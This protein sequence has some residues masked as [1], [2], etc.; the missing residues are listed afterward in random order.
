M[1]RLRKIGFVTAAILLMFF[2]SCRGGG[3]GASKLADSSARNRTAAL[4]ASGTEI[5]A[6]GDIPDF[7]IDRGSRVADPD[8]SE[9]M[10]FSN[11]P[12]L[13]DGR[14]W[15]DKSV[16]VNTAA[17]DFTVTLSALSQ[18]FSVTD[19]YVIPADTVF[20]FDVSGSM[21]DYHVGGD[22]GPLRIQVLVEALNE[23]IDI[24]M[25]ANP[26]NRVAV[27]AYGGRSQG[28]ARVENILPLGRPALMPSATDYFKYRVSATGVHY[29]DVNTTN[30]RT[31]YVRVEGSTPTQWG[32]FEGANILT[33]TN[34]TGSVVN[35]LTIPALNVET[36]LEEPG[37][38]VT[39]TPNIILMTD[40]EPTMAWR[41]FLFDAPPASIT[42][43]DPQ[44]ILL[45]S[46]GFYYGDG[47]YGEMGV[48]VLTVLTAAHR[49]RLIGEHYFIDNPAHAGAA[50]N[51]ERKVGFYT[52]GLNLED[53]PAFK[54]IEGTMFP[55][56]PANTSLP[57]NAS[58]VRPPLAEYMGAGSDPNDPNISM[59]DLLRDFVNPT[60]RDIT[61]YAQ[62]RIAWPNYS[63][64]HV[65][66][67]INLVNNVLAQPLTLREA[68]YADEFYRATDVEDLREAFRQITTNIQKQSTP[69]VIDTPSGDDQFD[70]YLVFSDVLGEYMKFGKIT[71]F[72]FDGVPYSIDGLGEAVET[73][74]AVFGQFKEVLYQNMNYGNMIGDPGYVSETR[75]EDLIKSNIEA[76][77]LQQYNSVKYYART[78]RDFLDSFFDSDGREAPADV[79]AAAVVEVFHMWGG[80]VGIE[81]VI[82]HE[83]M[84][85]ISIPVQVITALKDTAF[86][87]IFKNDFEENSLERTLKAGDQ[88]IRWYIPAG[89]I[90]LRIVS[91]EGNLD[92][93]NC[94]VLPI[95]VRYTVGLDEH[96]VRTEGVSD[97][98]MD[99]NKAPGTK[100][101]FYFYTNRNPENVTYAFY[102]PHKDN[103]FY[104]PGRPGYGDIE[105]VKSYN[106]TGT[107]KHVT[108]NRHKDDEDEGRMNLHWLGNNGRLTITFAEKL[109]S[110]KIIKTFE[111]LP[112]DGQIFNLV[113]N[114]RFQITGKDAGG[115][116]WQTAR[117]IYGP[118]EVFF[119]PGE[120]VLNA[121]LNRYEYTLVDLPPGYYQVREAGGDAGPEFIFNGPQP[122][123]IFLITDSEEP[124]SVHF[125]NTYT[126][127]TH[128]DPPILTVRKAFQG[129]DGSQ[130]PPAFQI[131][132]TGPAG[133]NVTLDLAAAENGQTFTNLPS[134]GQYRI[135]EINTDVPGFNLS[136]VLVNGRPMEFPYFFD[137]SEA[138]N[139]ISITINNV[140]TPIPP[141]P[142]GGLT[143][144]K[145]FEGLPPEDIFNLVSPITFLVV[146]T[147][148]AYNEIYRK[149]VAFTP[150]NF[151]L[152]VALN[153][154]ECTLTNLPLG[155]YRIYENGGWANGYIFNR[156]G[157]PQVISVTSPGAIVSVFFV[158]RYTPVDPP[159]KLPALTVRK[160]FQGLVNVEKP[161]T[162]QIHITGPGGFDKIL[163]IGA[164]EAG[165][166]FQDLELGEYRIE[167]INTGAPGFDLSQVL[168]DG[169]PVTEWPYIVEIYDRNADISLTI[170]N[171]YTPEPPP[172]IGNL[173]II[174]AFVGLPPDDFFDLVSP[175]TFLVVGTDAAY[176]EIYRKTVAFTPDNFTWNVAL[177]RYECTLTNLP[178]GNYR[179]YENGGWADG[180]IF[181]RPGPPQLISLTSPGSVVSVL[182]INSYEPA[183]PPELPAL[184]VRKAFHGLANAQKP[185]DFYIHITGPD[186]F[187]EKLFIDDAEAGKTF[188]NLALGEYAIVEINSD[189]PGFDLS[190]IT[191][192]GE[193]VEEWPYKI[194]I[195]D[196]SVHIS[197]TINNVYT[198]ELP[199]LTVLKAFHGLA[200]AQKPVGFYIHI[201]G[202]DG[203]DEKMLIDDAE[204]GKTF[205]NLAL[206]EYAIVEIN[207]DVPGFDLSEIT[208]NGEL[209]EEWPYKIVIS[210]TSVHISI[211]INNV[212]TPDPPDPPALTVRKAFHGLAN[213]QKPVGFYIHITGPGGF[214]EKV[215]INDA[216]AG[217]TFQNLAPGEYSIVEINSDVPGFDLS[218]ITINGE[219]VKKWPYKII[220][221]DAS[222]HISIT[223]NNVYTPE[224]PDPS[225][226][227]DPPTTPPIWPPIWPP[228]IYPWPPGTPPPTDPPSPPIEPPS[229]P[230]NPPSPPTDPP[231]IYPFSPDPPPPW[232]P[233]PS[234]PPPVN[235]S[236]PEPPSP[237]SPPPPAPPR[238][239]QTGD[240]R[241]TA[242]YFIML[243][244]GICF[245]GA[246]IGFGS[247]KKK[248]GNDAR[249]E[250]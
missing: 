213:A 152:N 147:D 214:D 164:S 86:D 46:P 123:P 207:S 240:Y 21:K 8:T 225:D 159:E 55:F 47:S 72:E 248:S 232:S 84:D 178:L 92:A 64:N 53:D 179:I 229:P 34:V 32:I 157:A 241:R 163:D 236:P 148:A 146:G 66:S 35:D 189:V 155:S 204:A 26:Q 250:K 133:F 118:Q 125:L 126:T 208:I 12:R 101:S 145:T 23:A 11:V 109:G 190:E 108:S 4:K 160:A 173:T 185:V 1:E 61:F 222:V 177:N 154:Y 230:I 42:G 212:Y 36:G 165:Q 78:N 233:P 104:H 167:E 246:A 97:E 45:G 17:D 200:N 132:I 29:V 224:P 40:G 176:N 244:T 95:R 5:Y 243:L 127:I 94:N 247:Q 249:P 43:T 199:A 237:W 245:M 82:T 58:I 49:K 169:R 130:K 122:S 166:T 217:K 18:S 193:L 115:A 161:F 219:L 77:H 93:A 192:N 13:H 22:D 74:A 112:S 16:K 131:R 137:I 238:G 142:S 188:Q 14:V 102:R 27:V 76:G 89:L 215:F 158:N 19:G 197:I 79:E 56:D 3:G 113:P 91:A 216:E 110:L 105:V 128:P 129:L 153:R 25:S 228:P 218:E 156:P 170:I 184:T 33:N 206:G 96:R 106:S 239:P 235:P 80:G 201:T 234:S 51:A 116:S 48:S 103:P 183:P 134:Y 98:Y 175:I 63:W 211:T 186:G 202:P 24:L 41:D 69:N 65:N 231:P 44:G 120:F 60:K 194:I 180:Y 107:A 9:Q 10:G 140:Y 90:P 2:V 111:G 124:V 138:N 83:V 223:I 162:F 139:E 121:E 226:P 174:K 191:I 59:E 172:P 54:I 195:A 81:N 171:I 38:Y 209:V 39:R 75:V 50:N 117:I 99:A 62:Y 73:R 37:I 20:I 30:R 136:Q 68:A 71:S 135:E 220:I 149:T 221:S 7:E 227:P 150:D 205:Q 100:D 141:P 15:A 143:I 6:N 57:G 119:R 151:T 242:P 187:D 31:P 70:G 210:D 28:Y 88:F 144:V 114:L 182:F 181:N 85:F 168:I 196:A 52:I 67:R 198:P 87:E 203:F